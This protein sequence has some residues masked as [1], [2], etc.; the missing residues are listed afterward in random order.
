ML[1]PFPELLSFAFLLG[2]LP[3]RLVVGAFLITVSVSHFRAKSHG[4]LSRSRVVLWGGFEF[5][6][7]ALFILGAYTQVAALAGI[8]ASL[9]A[10]YFSKMTPALAPYGRW[11]YVFL[12]M[13]SLSL[14]FLGAGAFAFDLPL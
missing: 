4:T 8:A 11:A 2:P 9:V 13:A 12:G 1:N 6:V 3:L 5:L 10:L 14:L 7:G